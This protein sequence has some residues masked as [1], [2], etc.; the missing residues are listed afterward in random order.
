M[1]D[2][3]HFV[4]ALSLALL[5]G[6]SQAASI[7]LTP[8]GPLEVATGDV[9]TFSVA[10]DFVDFEFFFAGGFDLAYDASA[11]ELVSVVAPV[12]GDPTLFRPPTDSPGL[13][14]G[15]VFSR[16]GKEKLGSA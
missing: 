2:G 9:V 6:T 13:L 11:L 3:F 8:E 12:I 15:W 16:D 7:S 14:E 1:R 4:A 10:Y 5:P